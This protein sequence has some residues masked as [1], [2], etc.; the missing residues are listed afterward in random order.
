MGKT[1]IEKILSSHS[2]TPL[3]ADDVGICKVDFC[4]SQDGTSSL[5]R[6]SVSKFK[7]PLKSSKKY[8]M[9]IDH[10]SPSPNIGVSKVHS[11]MREFSKKRLGD[12]YDKL[13]GLLEA[14][15]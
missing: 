15:K 11:G 10:S 9:F 6:E 7:R 14:T 5:V 8:A 2:K 4:F 13:W 12:M 1:I 3:N